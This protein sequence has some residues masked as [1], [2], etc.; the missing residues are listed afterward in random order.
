MNQRRKLWA[1]VAQYNVSEIEEKTA[2]KWFTEKISNHIF[3]GTI[4]EVD[5][6]L[7][8]AVFDKEITNVDMPRALSSRLS[9]ILVHLHGTLV[10]LI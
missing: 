2:L 3:S 5:V 6:A 1:L 4:K 8:N 7:F 10:V 9:P